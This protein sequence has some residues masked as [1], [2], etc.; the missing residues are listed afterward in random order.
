MSRNFIPK[1][2]DE[3]DAERWKEFAISA[4]QNRTKHI[5]VAIGRTLRASAERRDFVDALVDAVI[6]WENLVGSQKGEPTLRVS[7]SL[8][9]LLEDDVAKRTALRSELAKLYHLRSQVVHCN[10]PPSTQELAQKSQ[11]ALELTVAALRALFTARLDLLKEC[12]DGDERSN[13][14]LMGG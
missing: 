6:A 1:Q 11:R 13:R 4:E 9:W 12:K 14:L 5:D 8:A 2:L 7:A 10:E 3:D